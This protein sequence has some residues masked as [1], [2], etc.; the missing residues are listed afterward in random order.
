MGCGASAAD[1]DGEG[2]A[3]LKDRV[4]EKKGVSLISR[5]PSQRYQITAIESESDE[6]PAGPPPLSPLSIER[7]EVQN[8]SWICDLYHIDRN[9]VHRSFGTVVRRAFH[10]SQQKQRMIKQFDTS[11]LEMQSVLDEAGTLEIL[12]EHPNVI[13]LH[14]T[15]KDGASIWFVMEVCDGGRLADEIRECTVLNEREASTVLQQMLRAV[16][17]MHKNMV[18]HRCIKPEHVLLR[19]RALLV[20]CELKLIGFARSALFRPGEH[21]SD[22]EVGV[23]YYNSPQVEEGRYTQLCD[24]WSCGVVLYVCLCGY[25]S[26]RSGSKRRSSSKR[27]SSK[28][29]REKDKGG[30]ASPIDMDTFAFNEEKWTATANARDF[31]DSLIQ[32]REA[33]RVPVEKALEH[34]WIRRH[35][36]QKAPMHKRK[37]A[38]EDT[39]VM[40]FGGGKQRTNDSAMNARR[41]MMSAGGD[42]D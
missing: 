29:K 24:I 6:E 22:T 40:S 19:N 20:D 37:D 11:K 32:H 23:P 27:A 2:S 12:C 26:G 30:S 41:R 16:Q 31:L 39:P 5:G 17:Y 4:S 34:E 7:R 15:F 8:P 14:E 36:P 9:V 21:F 3:D 28:Q 18:C 35:A 10:K 25:P 33:D 38:I 13:R 1:K 42:S